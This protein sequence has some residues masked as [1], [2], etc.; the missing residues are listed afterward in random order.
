MTR[1]VF[2]HIAQS[3]PGLF[4]AMREGI[5]SNLE[6]TRKSV[7]SKPRI[8]HETFGICISFGSGKEELED[9]EDSVVF[10]PVLEA[11]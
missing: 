10:F 9:A 1:R 7:I 4:L 11:G 3:L 5:L 2:P 6:L 8:K